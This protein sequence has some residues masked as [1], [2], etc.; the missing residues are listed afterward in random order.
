MIPGQVSW[1][2][3]PSLR[4]ATAAL[5]SERIRLPGEPVATGCA[6]PITVAGPR[7]D[8]TRFPFPPRSAGHPGD[9]ARKV[10]HA[11]ARVNGNRSPV[12]RA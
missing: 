1:L 11:A 3:A 5:R 12:S 9:E 8:L 4:A 2:R 7:G 6:S 10:T